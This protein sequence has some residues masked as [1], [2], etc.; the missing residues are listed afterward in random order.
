MANQWAVASWFVES[1]MKLQRKLRSGHFLAPLQGL[2]GFFVITI[3][4][5]FSISMVFKQGKKQTNK[6][7]NKQTKK[8]HRVFEGMIYFWA[9]RG[10]LRPGSINMCHYEAHFILSAHKFMV[11]LG[12]VKGHWEHVV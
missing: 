4:I 8:T 6:Q 11:A 10:S 1:K 12:L 9:R 5:S 2:N 7:T 3:S